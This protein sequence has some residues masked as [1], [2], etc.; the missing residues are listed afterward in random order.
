[1]TLSAEIDALHRRYADIVTTADL[2]SLA[3]VYA[4]DA[5]SQ[6][7][8]VG[9]FVG[10]EAIRV[11]LADELE[12]LD[13]VI[14]VAHGG[15]STLGRDSAQSRCYVTEWLGQRGAIPQHLV[16]L[17]EDE[18]IQTDRG[19]R[20]QTVGTSSSFAPNSRTRRG[21]AIAPSAIGDPPTAWRE[22]RGIHEAI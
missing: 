8:T 16:G 21:R 14:M 20:Y 11:A 3:D 10:L 6:H 5:I 19:W 2:D 9:R 1:M 22:R 17:Y 18:L 13:F 15:P 12:H 4:R 7:P